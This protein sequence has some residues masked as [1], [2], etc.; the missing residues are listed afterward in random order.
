[1]PTVCRQCFTPYQWRPKPS[2]WPVWR[3]VLE[4]LGVSLIGSLVLRCYTGT[5]VAM[6]PVWLLLTV[7]FV[8][9]VGL[10]WALEVIG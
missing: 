1:M 9:A 5:D 2:S 4:F 8:L 7:G 10:V 6:A 3:R